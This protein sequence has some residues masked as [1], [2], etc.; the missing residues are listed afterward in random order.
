[1]GGID[2]TSLSIQVGSA[3]ITYGNFI[4]AVVNFIL[5]GL[6]LFLVIKGINT[7]EN[8]LSAKKAEEKQAEPPP[9]AE[10]IMLLREIRDLLR[11]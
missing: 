1:M 6:T 5:I 2:F 9:P 11:K 3:T 10:D 4:Q 7:A 8:R